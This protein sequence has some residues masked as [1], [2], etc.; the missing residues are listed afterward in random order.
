VLNASDLKPA[1]KLENLSLRE[2]RIVELPGLSLPQLQRLDLA[3]NSITKISLEHF[4][5]KY[6]LLASERSGLS[7]RGGSQQPS[8]LKLSDRWIPFAQRI[9]G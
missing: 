1:R 5:G 6:R 9:N 8:S 4:E 2:N 3:Y 7:S